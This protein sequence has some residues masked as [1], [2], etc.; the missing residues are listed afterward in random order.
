MTSRFDLELKA[1]NNKFKTFCENIDMFIDL[2]KSIKP[3]TKI[4]NLIKYTIIH[5]LNV[6][7]VYDIDE[8]RFNK[9]I[10]IILFQRFF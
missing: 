2:I 9:S 8:Y 10:R 3:I 7:L 4:L 1:D 6:N 5:E